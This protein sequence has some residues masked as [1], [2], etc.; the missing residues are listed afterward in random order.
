MMLL[1]GHRRLPEVNIPDLDGFSSMMSRIYE[2]IDSIKE[3]FE[4][5]NQAL[6]ELNSKVDAL[7]SEIAIMAVNPSYNMQ[8]LPINSAIASIRYLTGE[9]VFDVLYLVVLFGCLFTIVIICYKIEKIV[10][11]LFNKIVKPF[12]SSLLTG[13]GVIS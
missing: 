3:G 13:L 5:T 9:I 6:V 2:V 12:F 4:T 8:G 10:E 7:S 1:S 11:Y